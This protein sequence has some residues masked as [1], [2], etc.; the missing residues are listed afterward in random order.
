[1]T[2]TRV[3]F[4]GGE[5][6]GAGRFREEF[7]ELVEDCCKVEVK[8]ADEAERVLVMV[9]GVVELSPAVIGAT[10]ILDRN[11]QSQERNRLYS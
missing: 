2:G 4:V 7:V 6:W 11:E 10:S 1:M 5:A 3:G 9:M 8:G